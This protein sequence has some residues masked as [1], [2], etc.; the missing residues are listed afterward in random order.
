MPIMFNNTSLIERLPNMLEHGLRAQAS[1]EELFN[2]GVHCFTQKGV[3]HHNNNMNNNGFYVENGVFG[4]GSVNIGAEVGEMFVPPLES[5]NSI[6]DSS[7]HKLNNRDTTNTNYN[8]YYDNINNIVDNYTSSGNNN[9][10]RCDME[11]LFHEEL[12][13]GE[14]DLE[15][16]MK[17]VSSFPFLDF[18]SR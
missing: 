2:N 11:N 3:D 17:D 16:L 4:I 15:E 14:W 18:S 8:T 10:S 12:T 9:N 6:T 5:V 7:L 1:S 13:L